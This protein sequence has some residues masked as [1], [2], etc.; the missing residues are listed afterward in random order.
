LDRREE[1]YLRLLPAF[2]ALLSFGMV[3]IVQKDQVSRSDFWSKRNPIIF[4]DYLEEIEVVNQLLF[5][6]CQWVAAI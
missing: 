4:L 2:I 3:E 1:P 6:E 5:T